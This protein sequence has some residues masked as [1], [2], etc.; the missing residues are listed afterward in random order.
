MKQCEKQQRSSKASVVE[1]RL[2]SK[3]VPSI[4]SAGDDQRFRDT[5]RRYATTLI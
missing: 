1:L 2:S 5:Q 4:Q 3:S